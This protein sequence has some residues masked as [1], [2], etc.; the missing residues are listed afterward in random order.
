MERL[1][2]LDAEFL[3]LE[4]GYVNMA[5]AGS[6][7]FEGPPP[8]FAELER[9]VA[10]K[11]HQIPRYR[12]H[13][14]PVPFELGRP[15]WVDDPHF[16]LG[17]HLRH[18]ALPAPGDDAAFCRLMGRIM[19]QP[20]DRARPLWETWVVEGL[21]GDRWAVV[22][23]IHHCMVDGIA[24]VELLAVM[25]DFQ[26]DAVIGEPLPWTPKPEPAG[27][28]KVLDA[29]S[30]LLSDT[31]A[32]VRG[33]P[34]SLL[35]P[36][37][38]LRSTLATAE[39][40]VRFARRLAPTKPLS[41]E[42]PIGPHRSWAHSSASLAD[43][44]VIRSAFGG[45]VND[46]V[47]AAVSGGYRALLAERGDDP[48]KAVVRSLVPVSTRHEDARGVPDNRVSALL[49]ELPVHLDDP[50]ER[51]EVVHAQMSKLKTS[52]ISEA[53]EAVATIGNLAPPMLVG[54]ASRLVIRSMGVL[55]Q[56]SLNTVTTNVP[57]PQFPLYCLGRQMLEYRPYVPISHGLRVGTAILSYNGNIF[58]GVTGDYE[59]MP[60]VGVLA[61]AVASGIDELRE[62]ALV[63]L[64]HRY[65]GNG[66]SADG[67]SADGRSADGHAA[68]ARPRKPRAAAQ[69][70]PAATR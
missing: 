18:T 43:V 29:W 21:E 49:Y 48:D 60:D 41:I 61:T 57:G 19:S 39:G 62:H 53:G 25:L 13:V 40:A 8:P 4:D 6:C 26:R 31:F 30:G 65:S 45:T 56:H 3:H 24:G 38:A 42:G 59:T 55:G 67:R 9:L 69:R 7:V 32:A 54:P 51:L 27:V 28:M 68:T 35:H 2:A 63:R 16:D 52:H 15:I 14:R 70:R 33:V 36:A 23:K 50:V 58:F 12:Q 11:I 47:L 10:S 22:F 34:E 44:K 1:N 64:G 5:I 20:L 66:R 37:D 17:Y 46:V